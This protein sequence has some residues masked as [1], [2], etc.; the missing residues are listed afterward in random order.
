MPYGKPIDRKKILDGFENFFGEH[1]DSDRD[2]TNAERLKI[3]TSPDRASARDQI[4]QEKPVADKL[5]KL[6]KKGMYG[7]KRD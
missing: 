3:Q 5:M 7:D 6:L 2:L 4:W 1:Y